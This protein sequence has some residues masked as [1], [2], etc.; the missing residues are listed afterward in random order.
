MFTLLKINHLCIAAILLIVIAGISGCVETA[1]ISAS[2]D[3]GQ[4]SSATPSAFVQFPDV[5]I[6]PNTSIN[7]KKTLVVGAKPWFGRLALESFTGANRTFDFFI[8]KMSEHGWQLKQ[9]VRGPTYILT[10]EN[11]ERQMTILITSRTLAGSEITITVSPIEH[12]Q[13]QSPQG[14]TTPQSIIQ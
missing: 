14:D 3:E 4:E 6:P 5:A 7:V 9:A 12:A 1:T 10:Y 13:P 2:E 8:T 11:N